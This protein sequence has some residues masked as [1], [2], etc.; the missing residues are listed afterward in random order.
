MNSKPT[1]SK[2]IAS[3]TIESGVQK[4]TTTHTAL[5]QV[6]G[7]NVGELPKPSDSKDGSK[8]LETNAVGT[9]KEIASSNTGSSAQ[10]TTPTQSILKEVSERNVSELPKQSNSKDGSEKVETIAVGSKNEATSNITGSG[11]QEAITSDIALKQVS[12]GNVGELPKPSDSKNGSAKEETN[13]VESKKQISSSNTGSGTPETITIDPTVKKVSEGNVGELSKPSNSKDGFAEVGTNAVGST[14]EIASRS[15]GS[16]VQETI[17]T[18]TS[19]KQVSEG[20]LSEVP[21]QSDSEDGSTKVETNAVGSTKEVASSNAR[22]GVQGTITAHT[23]LKQVSEGI[24]FPVCKN[25]SSNLYKFVDSTSM[26][27]RR[28]TYAILIQPISL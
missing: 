1:S 7:G 5:K 16:D 17:S 22:S 19:L 23:A 12:E 21:K 6:S 3:S 8:K 11:V 26:H 2:E 4:P 27:L 28:S 24:F 10:E 14:N 15:T 9:T 20:N 25:C 13:A 18:H